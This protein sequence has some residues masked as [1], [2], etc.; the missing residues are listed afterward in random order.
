MFTIFFDSIK[1]SGEYRDHGLIEWTDLIPQ[2]IRNDEDIAWAIN[3]RAPHYTWYPALIEYLGD[4][5]KSDKD[6]C[7]LR[8]IDSLIFDRL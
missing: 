1:E 7:T 6:F 5:L 3:P 8:R 2:R 4:K